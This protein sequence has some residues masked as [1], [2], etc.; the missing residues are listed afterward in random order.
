MLIFGPPAT[1][2]LI[3]TQGVE[4]VTFPLSLFTCQ[5]PSPTSGHSGQKKAKHAHNSKR[6][7]K[8]RQI[9]KKEIWRLRVENIQLCVIS[10]I[11]VL[12]FEGRLPL[13]GEYSFTPTRT[14][15]HIYWQ[16][17]A[18]WYVSYFCLC[19]SHCNPQ[20][21]HIRACAE[22]KAAGLERDL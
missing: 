19:L 3:N 1:P 17:G 21:P 10:F 13:L 2:L 7:S 14:C 8:R 20:W 9:F 15:T 16:L 22:Q 11:C 4:G 18:Y 12:F 5:K 6:F